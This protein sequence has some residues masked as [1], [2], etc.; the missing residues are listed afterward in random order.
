MPLT[1]NSNRQ[2]LQDAARHRRHALGL[3]RRT[4]ATDPPPERTIA[5]GLELML[6][7]IRVDRCAYAVRETIGGP[8]RLAAGIGWHDG[9]IG[10]ATL[11]GGDESLGGRTLLL[12][13]PL[14]VE[15]I[16]LFPAFGSE[17][18][19]R[20]S[21]IRSA[22]TA[23]VRGQRGTAGLMAAFGGKK[24]LFSLDES[25]FL[26]GLADVIAAALY[27]VEW[28]SQMAIHRAAPGRSSMPERWQQSAR[29]DDR[30]AP[31]PA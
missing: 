8:F 22:L 17:P 26:V 3:F 27:R 9:V 24:G 1:G 5:D 23:P 31:D 13:R 29:D 16:S 30:A 12:G 7:F 4:A 18:L 6:R 15:D 25:E 28:R 14:I 20:S 19:L 11:T 2:I 21:G 10:R